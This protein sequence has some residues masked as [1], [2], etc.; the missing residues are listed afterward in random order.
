MQTI[1]KVDI[2]T[3]DDIILC[4][5]RMECMVFHLPWFLTTII[6]T[7]PQNKYTF[8]SPYSRITLFM[9]MIR[10]DI[11]SITV[12]KRNW[13]SPTYWY[14]CLSM[15][16]KFI[17]K[18]NSCT[19]YLLT[20]LKWTSYPRAFPVRFVESGHVEYGVA[21]VAYNASAWYSASPYMYFIPDIW[22]YSYNEDSSYI[23]KNNIFPPFL[24]PITIQNKSI[25]YVYPYR[26]ILG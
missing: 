11:Y 8:V 7:R 23:L 21:I 18:S 15:G 1:I 3:D 2:Q 5:D 9:A 16:S 19:F 4:P 13:W 25:G 12:Q 10:I 22:S 17:L 6:Y 26:L 24:I 14:W 20:F